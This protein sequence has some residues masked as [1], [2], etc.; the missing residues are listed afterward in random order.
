MT[1]YIRYDIV[2]KGDVVAAGVFEKEFPDGLVALPLPNGECVVN[3]WVLS[4]DDA[5]AF[6]KEHDGSVISGEALAKMNK[7]YSGDNVELSELGDPV[8]MA[9]PKAKSK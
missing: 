9:K 7:P 5:R 1:Q 2:V 3:T 6:R 4:P 8:P